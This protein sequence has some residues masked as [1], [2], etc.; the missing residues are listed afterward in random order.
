MNSQNY[1]IIDWGTTN[2]RAFL[3]DSN[4]QLQQ[5]IERPMGLLQVKDGNFADVLQA[6]LSEWLADFTDL[7]V[8]MAGMV[9]S[10]KGWHNVAYIETPASPERLWHQAFHFQLPWKPKAVI[11]PGVCDTVQEQEYDVMRGEEIQ[12]FGLAETIQH[13]QFTAIFPGTHSKHVDVKDGLIQHFSSYLTGEFYSILSQHSLLGKGL[14]AATELNQS[15]FLRGVKEG[16]SG[17]LTNR[18]FLT[19]TH[20]LFDN[21]NEDEALDYLS[22]VLI[23]YELSEL[24]VEHAYI[25]GGHSLSARYQLALNSMNIETQIVNGDDCFLVGMTSLIKEHKNDS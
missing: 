23:G 8:Y 3:M 20:R 12:I 25:V 1:L 17:K 11:F 9:G 22:G 10:A 15:S 6:L 16:Q 13:S 7:P 2:F 19:W 5:K 24:A 14:T 4:H 21:L 18:V